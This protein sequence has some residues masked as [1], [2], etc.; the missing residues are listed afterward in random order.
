MKTRDIEVVQ[1]ETSPV[2]NEV[3]AQSVVRI[4]EGIKKLNATPLNRKGLVVLISA[5]T[6]VS[7]STVDRVLSG[8]DTLEAT[9]I[10][11]KTKH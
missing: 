1:D 11:K 5:A 4:A 8:L 9:Y 7:R 6:G 3:L 10:K 2:A